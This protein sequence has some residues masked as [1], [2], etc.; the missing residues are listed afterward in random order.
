MTGRAFT[1]MSKFSPSEIAHIFWSMRDSRNEEAA[2]EILRAL[3][4]N[5]VEQMLL[6]RD[7]MRFGKLYEDEREGE[8]DKT[9]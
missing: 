7:L 5:P 3:C 9:S 4:L 6:I 8:G 1:P 2:L